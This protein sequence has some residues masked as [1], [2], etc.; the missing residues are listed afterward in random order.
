M[1]VLGLGVEVVDLVCYLFGMV[2]LSKK[3]AFLGDI[4]FLTIL[5]VYSENDKVRR[6][7]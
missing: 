3:E 4:D 5:F 7:G 2:S 1:F 6:H